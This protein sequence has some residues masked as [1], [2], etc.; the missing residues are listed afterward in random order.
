MNDTTVYRDAEYGALA[1]RLGETPRTL[2]TTD[3]GLAEADFEA[4]LGV[5]ESRAEV[6][7][8]DGSACEW[9]L[10][11]HPM[12]VVSS[13]N[14]VMRRQGYVDDALAERA[15]IRLPLEEGWAP[16]LPAAEPMEVREDAVRS[17]LL[18]LA[19]L[20]EKAAGMKESSLSANFYP[21]PNA[22]GIFNEPL[23]FLRVQ[24]EGHA[25][26]PATVQQD[27]RQVFSQQEGVVRITASRSDDKVVVEAAFA[28]T[29][30]M[31]EEYEARKLPS[32]RDPKTGLAREARF[33]LDRP[34]PEAVASDL[35]KRALASGAALEVSL[36]ERAFRALL[37]CS[38]IRNADL[39]ER[40][41][42]LHSQIERWGGR[43]MEVG[44]LQEVGAVNC[45]QE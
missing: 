39:S 42:W 10:K 5:L 30:G 32:F 4:L 28:P 40:I 29:R 25:A 15:I 16:D 20:V 7:R 24:V 23:P 18:S 6:V 37:P 41:R 19:A 38:Q 44:E 45:G 12:E 11:A 27:V 35:K 36:T 1:I 2:V 14:S 26:D 31:L 43:V 9:R 21:R 22:R 17:G 3:Y 34:L 8:S 33:S 13:V